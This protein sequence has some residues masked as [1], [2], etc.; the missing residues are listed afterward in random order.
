MFFGKNIYEWSLP[1]FNFLLLLF[2]LVCHWVEFLIYFVCQPHQICGSQ[3]F[4]PNKWVAFSVYLLSKLLLKS[5]LFWCSLTC[6]FFCFIFYAFDVIS[7][8]LFLR[9]MSRH[10]FSIFFSSRSFYSSRSYIY[11]CVLFWADNAYALRPRSLKAL[12][13]NS[14]CLFID[15]L[16]LL[17]KT[18]AL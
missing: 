8:K 7:K 4:L 10:I 14:T 16:S 6:S 2:G 12:L 3:I 1:I 15:T 5:F 9:P 18:S 17:S 13:H 11:V